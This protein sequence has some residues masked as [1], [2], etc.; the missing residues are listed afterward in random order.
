MEIQGTFEDISPDYKAFCDKFKPK[1]TTDDCYTPENIFGV[2]LEWAAKKY[3]FKTSQVVRP[4]WQGGD[5]EREAYLDGAVVVDN[6]PFSILSKI[7]RFYNRNGIPFLL[8]APALTTFTD[9]T[10]G[11]TN[12][13]CTGA[14]VTYANGAVVNTSFVTNM[15]DNL[16]ETAPELRAAIID[17]DRENSLKG[18]NELPSYE[19]PPD[20][21]T[22]S[23]MNFLSVHG[24]KFEVK[25]AEAT[26]VRD[27]DAMAGTGKS[28]FG[29]G[30]L[31]DRKTTCRRIFA[32]KEAEAN[33]RRKELDNVG[34]R[35]RIVWELSPREIM[36]QILIRGGK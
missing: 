17:A 21:V 29:G 35:G 15:G 36:L 3:G 11:K 14:S 34:K 27:L 7:V 30:W 16:I 10:G 28:I 32:D 5:Y 20:V 23:D 19:Y 9:P 4:F 2:V 22:A 8:F 31:L 33:K 6:P 26:F 13:I 1:K 24:V 25:R 12:Y 18:K